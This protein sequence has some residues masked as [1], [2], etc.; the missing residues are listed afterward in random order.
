MLGGHTESTI[1]QLDEGVHMETM[2]EHLVQPTPNMD[3]AQQFENQLGVANMASTHVVH[4]VFSI[5]DQLAIVLENMPR[6]FEG[7]VED[8]PPANGMGT[9]NVNDEDSGV[10]LIGLQKACQSLYPS[11]RPTMLLM[12]ICTVHGVSNKFVDELLSLLHKYLLPPN[13]CLS[14]NMYHA[15]TLTKTVGFNYHIIHACPN[16]F[17]LFRGVHRT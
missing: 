6:T 8:G 1:V 2:L 7:N 15:K 5:V 17:I 11:A 10:H 16:G 13:N 4:E 12:N 3:R 9:T 14:S